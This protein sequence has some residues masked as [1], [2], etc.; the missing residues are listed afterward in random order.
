[1]KSTSPICASLRRSKNKFTVNFPQAIAA[2]PNRETPLTNLCPTWDKDLYG[3]RWRFMG[4]RVRKLRYGCRDSVRS[5]TAAAIC[6]WLLAASLAVS[7]CLPGIVSGAD[8]INLTGEWRFALDRS[9]ERL[10]PQPPG[11]EMPVLNPGDGI[12]QE[13]FKRDLPDKIRLPGILQAQ[14]YGDD[15]STNTPWVLGLGDAWW[16]LQPA[17]LREHFSQTGHVEVPFLSQPP[18][19]Y[20]GA[21]WYQR[22]IN[23][24]RNW[25]GRHVTLFLERPHWKSTAWLDDTEIG[26][27]DSLC[28]PHQFEVGR[29][30]A[31]ASRPSVA[32]TNQ[33]LTGETPVPLQIVPGKHRLTI[34]VD[35]RTQLPNVGHL[36]DAHSVSDAL[37]ATWNGIVGKIELRATTPVWIEDAQIF[38]NV[39]SNS[40][41]L[42]VRIGNATGKRGKGVLWL[43]AAF[44]ALEWETNGGVAEMEFTMLGAKL[45][46]EFHPELTRFTVALSGSD[47]DDSREIVFGQ[48][49]ITAR[50]KDLLING[51]P[52]NLRLTHFGGDF[53]LTGYPAMDVETWK[54]IIQV[55]KD[56]GLNGMRFHS[57]CPPDA[58]FTA[59]DEMGFYLQPECGMWN[60]FGSP[61]MQQRLDDETARLLIAYGNHPSFILLSPSN[62][63]RNYSRVTPRWAAEWYQKDNRRL[64]AAGTGWSDPSQVNGGAQFA[65]L[66]AFNRHPLRNTT[67]WFGRDYRA[68]LEN[69]H[70]PVLAHEVGQWCAYPDFDVIKEFTGYLRPGN[71]DIF[72]YIAEQQG[73]LDQNKIF[74]RA[75]G[76]FQ[77]ACY[78]EEIEANLRTPGL[79]G[80]QLLDLHD[81]LGQGTALIG[82]VDAFW[83]P[84]SYVAAPEF[85]HFSGPI[86]PLARLTNRVFTTADKFEAPVEMANFGEDPLTNATTKWVVLDTSG[87]SVAGGEFSPQ[88][89]PI[90]KNFALGTISLDLTNLPA[91]RQYKLVVGQASRLS[92]T[93]KNGDRRDAYPTFANDWNFWVYPAQ[94]ST[95]TPPDVL[96]TRFWDEAKTRLAAGGK[97]LFLP[98]N[99]SL[100]P[101]K[102]P[103]MKNV[104]VFWNIQMTVRPPQNP[105]PRFDAFLGLVC[106]TNHPALAEFPTDINC[107]WQWTRLVNNV[108][109]VNLNTA[110]RQLLPIVEA[111]DDWNRDWRL[112]VIFECNVGPGRL[113]VSAI[114]LDGSRDDSELLQLRRSVLDYMASNRF[115]PAVTLTAQEVSALWAVAPGATSAPARR[116][117]SDLN[118]GS[119][120]ATTTNAP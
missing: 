113:L 71:Y 52:L 119:I 14:G 5:Q 54:K 1:M 97:V 27:D 93:S 49:A 29:V 112:G 107:D 74:A 117:D 35:N 62:E 79:S 91:P 51:R 39:A 120:P 46:D 32:M 68:A 111:I 82:V 102:C 30:V 22:D 36:V 86:V 65:T 19:H 21:A 60:D 13:W 26:S 34:R 12:T 94:V 115:R 85:K 55:C 59:A 90:G 95:N 56:Y 87:R 110:P 70:I 69:V 104:P 96:V 100:D 31:R 50:D 45:W 6:G 61:A 10:E 16:K 101:A 84:K 53:P 4:R 17:E 24:P 109:P 58:A 99:A 41:M 103:P 73:V 105:R 15:I 20:L 78:K 63:P 81:Y 57:W 108:R 75:S 42:K 18:R 9:T 7:L 38:P 47:A 25:R 37:G 64:Y 77:V 33:N 2:G 98:D 92:K 66:V 11:R 89:I 80:F 48:R 116:F 106:Q 83:H 28:A 23:I 118:D 8:T 43:D 88:T 114:N 44:R 72:K 67:G 3:Q 76:R 40:A